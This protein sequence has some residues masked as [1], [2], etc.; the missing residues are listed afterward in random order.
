MNEE[1]LD[2]IAQPRFLPRDCQRD[3]VVGDRHE[4]MMDSF[5]PSFVVHRSDSM[6]PWW[7]L[8]Q[9][10]FRRVAHWHQQH[11]LTPGNAFDGGRRN[12]EM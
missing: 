7:W 6:N 4:R 1:S 12:A 5:D 8:S 10:Q 3:A 2:G 9:I 11:N